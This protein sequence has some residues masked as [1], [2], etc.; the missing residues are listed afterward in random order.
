[1][2]VV[3]G[4]EVR[5]YVLAIRSAHVSPANQRIL[6]VEPR[7]FEPLTS[8]VQRRLRNVAVVH[9]CSK[10]P[11]NKR[12]LSFRLSWVFA[13]VHLGWCQIVRDTL[14]AWHSL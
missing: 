10:T 3:S 13:G 4:V 12:I 1:M 9:Q 5:F 2:P 6:R 8:T 11:A 7:E 14:G